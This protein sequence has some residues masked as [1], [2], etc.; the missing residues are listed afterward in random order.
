MHLLYLG[1]GRNSGLNPEPAVVRLPTAGLDSLTMGTERG[2]DMEHES[3]SRPRR[4]Q[5]WNAFQPPRDEGGELHWQEHRGPEGGGR[6][7]LVV[8]RAPA[9]REPMSVLVPIRSTQREAPFALPLESKDLESG[10]G[11]V[12]D[13]LVECDQPNTFPVTSSSPKKPGL[14]SFRAPTKPEFTDRATQLLYSFVYGPRLGSPY[15]RGTLFRLVGVDSWP[16]GLLV[17]QLS[18]PSRRHVAVLLVRKAKGPDRDHPARLVLTRSD[19]GL[20]A[21]YAVHLR[22]LRTLSYDR[23]MERTGEIRNMLKVDNF[24]REYL[25]LSGLGLL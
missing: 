13:G 1:V 2:Q 11:G 18:D 14:R 16:Y 19:T 22:M 9:E 17:S 7:G 6:P 8:S 23:R 5:I 21:N 10:H 12:W 20:Q 15:P 25:A 24:L 4:G 3:S